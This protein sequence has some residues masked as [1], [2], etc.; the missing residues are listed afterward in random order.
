MVAKRLLLGCLVLSAAAFGQAPQ[1]TI[2]DLGSLTGFPACTATGL[3]QSG[4]VVGYCIGQ[5]GQSLLD[6]LPTHGFLYSA[7]AITDL[8]LNLKSLTSPLPMAVNDSG[9]IAGAD[10]D[11]D[12]VEVS[13]SANPF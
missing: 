7:G 4:N 1:F 9:I 10:V 12:V 8:N 6:S 2:T 5:L 11:I 3:S 13:V